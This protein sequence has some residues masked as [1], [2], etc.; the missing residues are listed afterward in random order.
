[1]DKETRL[2]QLYKLRD[3]QNKLSEPF[4]AEA[5]GKGATV[6]IRDYALEAMLDKEIKA[7]EDE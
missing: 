1:M 3:K 4:Y 5:D 2:K 7:L 6:R